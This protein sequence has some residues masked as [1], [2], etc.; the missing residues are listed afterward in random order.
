MT[1][2][3]Q[4]TQDDKYQSYAWL[5]ERIKAWLKRTDLKADVPEFI[6]FAELEINRRLK[7]TAKEIEA[8]LACVPGSRFVD[9]PADYGSAV[10]LWAVIDGRRC[11]L[12]PRLPE[13]LLVDDT[14]S[15]QP[16]YWTV[17]G[18][19]IG[20]SNPADRAYTLHLRYL[21]TLFLSDAVPTNDLLTSAPDLY[22]Y[23]ALVQAAPFIQQDERLPMWQSKFEALMRSTAAE[24]ARA[25]SMVPLQTELPAALCRSANTRYWG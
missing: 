2:F 15:T 17:D 4:S 10:A 1:I 16:Q 14:L 7:V 25:K 13:Q 3:A 22:V 18:A 6:R 19:R 21:R 11:E 5:Q 20:F 8:T 12:V 23:G 24:S 9:L